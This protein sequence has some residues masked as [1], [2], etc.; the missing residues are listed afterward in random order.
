MKVGVS[1]M[2]WLRYAFTSVMYCSAPASCQRPEN[3][4]PTQPQGSPL[5]YVP[6]SQVSLPSKQLRQ[7]ARAASRLK[8]VEDFESPTPLLKAQL[9]YG[10]RTCMMP[11][12]SP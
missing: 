6:P 11:N 12:D 7:P 9:Q 2:R 10:W 8:A 5:A 1:Q 4:R 3:H